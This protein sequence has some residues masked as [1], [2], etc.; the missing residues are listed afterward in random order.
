MKRQLTP[1]F[2]LFFLHFLIYPGRYQNTKLIQ[3]KQGGKYN[4]LAHPVWTRGNK[5]RHYQYNHH[6][7]LT[8]FTQKVRGNHTNFSKYKGQYRQLECQS[9]P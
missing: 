1:F 9:T 7:I 4:H 8:C 5:R 2:R 3:K 6:R